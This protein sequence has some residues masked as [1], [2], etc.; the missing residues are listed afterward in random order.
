MS[1]ADDLRNGKYNQNTGISEFE[2][3]NWIRAFKSVVTNHAKAAQR[4]GRNNVKGYFAYNSYDNDTLRIINDERPTEYIG[5][6]KRVPLEYI[7]E[8]LEIYLN[9]MGFH[10]CSVKIIDIQIWKQ[11]TAYFQKY[12]W[13]PYGK[14]KTIMVEYHW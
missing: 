9:E 7:R 12:K 1:F 8:M 4:S 13:V 3:N 10:R 5:L 11:E 14:D 6:Q 2:L